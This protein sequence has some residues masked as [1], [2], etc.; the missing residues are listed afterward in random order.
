MFV[1][2]VLALYLRKVKRNGLD[3][4]SEPGH[5]GPVMAGFEIPGL[6]AEI[7]KVGVK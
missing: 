3:F 5:F 2:V 1:K 6:Y 7:E 4:A